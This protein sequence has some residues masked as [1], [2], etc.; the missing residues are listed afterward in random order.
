MRIQFLNQQ[1][2]SAQLWYLLEAKT[3][4]KNEVVGTW[5]LTQQQTT[6]TIYCFNRDDVSTQFFL[7]F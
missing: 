7:L 1:A 4:C 6:D 2:Q 3:V 5:R